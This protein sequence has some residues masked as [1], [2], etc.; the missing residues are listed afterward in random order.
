MMWAEEIHWNKFHNLDSSWFASVLYLSSYLECWQRP[1][2]NLQESQDES[3][4][5]QFA[6]QC[7][8]MERKQK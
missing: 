8:M 4:L 7:P 3:H 5:S 1:V 2:P 6:S